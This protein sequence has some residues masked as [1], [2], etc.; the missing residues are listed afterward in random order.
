MAY[1]LQF[2]AQYYV[3]STP[4]RF[5]GTLS[6]FGPPVNPAHVREWT[7]NEFANFANTHGFR[8]LD[9]RVY[10]PQHTM[11]FLLER[12]ESQDNEKCSPSLGS[13][14]WTEHVD[15]VLLCKP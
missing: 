1:L 4:D 12:D 14:L 2:D 15:Y 13:R 11:W 9:A 7:H 6:Q 10:E 5:Y 3:V 8:V